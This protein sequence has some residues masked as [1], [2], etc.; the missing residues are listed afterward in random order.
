MGIQEIKDINDSEADS[1]TL[2]LKV[3]EGPQKGVAYQLKDGKKYT[4]GRGFE[5]DIVFHDAAICVSHIELHVKDGITHVN[6]IDGEV[7]VDDVT[8]AANDSH[9]SLVDTTIKFGDTQLCIDSTKLSEQ[10]LENKIQYK[11][12][13][14]ITKYDEKK[15]NN[16]Y[17][18]VYIKLVITG[19]FALLALLYSL[20][21]MTAKNDDVSGEQIRS[22]IKQALEIDGYKNVAV[23][24][25]GGVLKAS[26]YVEAESDIII[27]NKLLHSHANFIKNNVI[28]DQSIMDK[29]NDVLSSHEKIDEINV[30]SSSN[31]SIYLD[32]F[33]LDVNELDDIEQILRRDLIGLNDVVD[34]DVMT[35]EKLLIKIKKELKD[36]Y[37]NEDIDV[38]A[39]REKLLVSAVVSNSNRLGIEEYLGIY[40]KK[41]EGKIFINTKLMTIET[42]PL[43]LTIKSVTLGDIPY[44]TT[45]SGERYFRGALLD[46]GHTIKDITN[47]HIVL[48]RK[49]ITTNHIIREINL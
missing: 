15:E 16:L 33:V 14:S 32:G 41:Y 25:I 48:F 13:S 39:D 3:H 36:K 44:L 1:N 30:T 35:V 26:G 47:M 24:N 20:S 45:S 34:K 46:S 49:G 19:L 9:A 18:P 37:P 31:G 22:D 10:V 27:V 38:M 40:K 8:L 21:L 42:E 43:D 6:C 29:A 5:N 28:S 12:K 4:I 23:S 7:L 2:E 11:K 17:T